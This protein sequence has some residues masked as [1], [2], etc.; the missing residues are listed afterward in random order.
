MPPVRFDEVLQV[1]PGNATTHSV[2][3]PEDM[4]TVPV[5]APGS[6]LSESVELEPYGTDE[7]VA[8]AVNDVDSGVTLVRVTELAR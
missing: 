6:P 8:P 7:G 5:A 2:E 3:P 4:V 1:V